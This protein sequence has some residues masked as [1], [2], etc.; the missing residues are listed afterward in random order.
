MAR[1]IETKDFGP[2]QVE[3]E[4]IIRF[5]EGLFSFE[6]ATEFVF[7]KNDEYAAIWMQAVAGPDPRFIVFNPL[8]FFPGYDP[9]LPAG[10]LEQLA[11][12]SIEELCFFVIAVIPEKMRDMTVNLK[13]P[14]V[15][16]PAERIACQVILENEDYGVRH[17]VGKVE[18]GGGAD[19]DI[20]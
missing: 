20:E 13:S 7:I 9:H 3:E 11:A 19:A 15:V 2:I 5:P 10:V 16:N 8:D 1:E 17:R 14:V 12:Q 18:K 4:E 6:E